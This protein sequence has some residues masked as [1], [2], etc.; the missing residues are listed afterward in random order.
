MPC[1][2]GQSEAFQGTYATLIQ[3]CARLVDTKYVRKIDPAL[4]ALQMW[5]AAHGFIMLELAG[6]YANVADPYLEILVPMCNNVVVGLGAKRERVESA[7]A[8]I[9]ARWT[10]PPAFE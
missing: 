9:I 1:A 2:S 4:V 7:T 8:G 3:A 6:Y 10:S 5:S